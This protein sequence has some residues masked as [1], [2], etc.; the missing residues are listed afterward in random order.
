M[1]KHIAEHGWRNEIRPIE[2]EK[3]TESSVWV[4]GRR[5]QKVTHG[6]DIH[7]TWEEAHAYLTE[8][9]EMKVENCRAALERAKSVAGNISGMKRPTNQSK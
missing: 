8:V 4:D 9:A 5:I 7:D 1:L 2:V 6:K 3:E